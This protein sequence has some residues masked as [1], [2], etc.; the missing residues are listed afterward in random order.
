MDRWWEPFVVPPPPG[1]Y[2]P[3]EATPDNTLPA[4][5]EAYATRGFVCC[6]SGVLEA[7]FVKIAIYADER[8]VPQHVARQLA[9]GHWTSKLGGLEDIE[10]ATLEVLEDGDYGRVRM[11]LK[12]PRRIDDP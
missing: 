8:D 11:F 2:W 5:A 12:R 1:I 4:W 9:S 7:E 3:A 10:H 6:A